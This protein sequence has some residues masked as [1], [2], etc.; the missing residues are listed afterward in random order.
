[1]VISKSIEALLIGAL[2]AITII[3]TFQT[4][5]AYP[6]WVLQSYE[7]PWIFLCALVLSIVF[8]GVNPRIGAMLMLLLIALWMDWV[9]FARK[10]NATNLKFDGNY[11]LIPQKKDV[12]EIWP[13]DSPSITRQPDI[14]GEPTS[15]VP[16]AEPEYP[17]YAYTDDLAYGPAPFETT[18]REN[19]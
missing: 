16:F 17:T 11:A 18:I 14:Y 10:I 12:A 15:S 8:M 2:A 9:L 5:I 19:P 4:R 1:M 3:Y 13:Y 6:E 7:H